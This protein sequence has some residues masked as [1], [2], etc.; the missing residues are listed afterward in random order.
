MDRRCEGSEGIVDEY[1]LLWS[2]MLLID[3]QQHCFCNPLLNQYV[4]ITAADLYPRL[5]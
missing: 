1:G 2:V 4:F 3:H 5:P